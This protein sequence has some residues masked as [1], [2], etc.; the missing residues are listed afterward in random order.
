MTGELVPEVWE[1]IS[2]TAVLAA[3]GGKGGSS[4][5]GGGLSD[6]GCVIM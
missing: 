4:G 5:G 3:G 1:D 6:G 2:R